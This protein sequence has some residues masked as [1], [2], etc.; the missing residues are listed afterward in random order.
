MAYTTWA[1][2]KHPGCLAR[3]KADKWS[4]SAADAEGWFHTKAGDAFCPLHVPEWVP[5]WRARHGK[6][7]KAA[8]PLSDEELEI[9]LHGDGEG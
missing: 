8:E 4:N 9:A 3:H 5:A 1:F 7:S 2:C 6:K